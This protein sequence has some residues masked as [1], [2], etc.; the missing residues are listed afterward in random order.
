MLWVLTRQTSCES[1]KKSEVDA[2]PLGLG[3]EE[4]S[5]PKWSEAT[6]RKCP[7]H[8]FSR[9]GPHFPPV[10]EPELR[11]VLPSSALACSL[12][13]EQLDSLAG[14]FFLLLFFNLGNFRNVVKY[15]PIARLLKIMMLIVFGVKN[16]NCWFIW[17]NSLFLSYQRVFLV[18]E[19]TCGAEKVN[20]I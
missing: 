11:Q 18:W 1:F 15:F 7:W 5:R 9:V 14:F 20:E 8:L 12:P 19:P 13:K 2:V 3:S 4:C 17:T 6:Q 10:Q 16:P